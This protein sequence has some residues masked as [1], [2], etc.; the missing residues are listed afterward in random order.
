MPM[1]QIENI[2]VDNAIATAK[3][4]CDLDRCKGVCCCLEGGRGAPLDDHE[5]EQLERALP[6][7]RKCLS[8]RALSIINVRGLYEGRSGNYVVGCVEEKECIFVCYENGIANCAL[9]KAYLNGETTW[10]KPISCHL[11]PIRIQK[12]GGEIFMRYVQM[13]ECSQ[14]VARGERENIHLYKFLEDA[15][16]RAFGIEWYQQFQNQ[17]HKESA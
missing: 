3:F 5:I 12:Y 15:L 4:C 10:R 1:F 13:E 17:C 11:F 6:A 8:E 7:V 14:A 9:E 2:M 16:T